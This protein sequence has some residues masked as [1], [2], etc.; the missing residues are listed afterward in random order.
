MSKYSWLFFI[1]SNFEHYIVQNLNSK[2][3]FDIHFK[4]MKICTNCVIPETAETLTFSSEGKCSVCNQIDR[5][6]K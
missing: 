6:K 3:L 5:K 1:C 2:V 4:Y